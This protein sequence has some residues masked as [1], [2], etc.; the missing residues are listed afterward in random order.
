[1]ILVY[2]L[3]NLVSVYFS[4][5]ILTGTCSHVM[6]VL[7]ICA[8]SRDRQIN[9]ALFIARAIEAGNYVT[10]SVVIT[11]YSGRLEVCLSFVF[12]VTRFRNWPSDLYH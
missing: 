12:Q 1:M 10:G 6:T 11:V 7:D 9:G 8:D 5:W 3:T 4:E 2:L